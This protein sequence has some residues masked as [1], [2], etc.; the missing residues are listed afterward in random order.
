MT[1]PGCLKMSFLCINTSDDN[2]L[3]CP[4]ESI[5]SISNDQKMKY[6]I[7]LEEVAR[8][9]MINPKLMVFP[10]TTWAKKSGFSLELLHRDGK[11]WVERTQRR[12][13]WF[14]CLFVIKP[15]PGSWGGPIPAPRFMMKIRIYFIIEISAYCIHQK[16]QTKRGE[17]EKS[18]MNGI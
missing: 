18:L 13:W 12:R 5:L 17:V 9:E 6:F 2:K 10:F 14:Y 4:K 16:M 15:G 1:W 8:A 11:T 7:D 3:K